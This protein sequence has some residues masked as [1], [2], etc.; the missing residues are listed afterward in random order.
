MNT[1]V[2]LATQGPIWTLTLN[3]P[4]RLNAVCESLYGALEQ[5]LLDAEADPA[6]QVVI[7]A[8][9]GRAFCAGADLKLHQSGRTEAQ[10]RDYLWQEQRVCRQLLTLNKPV[11]CALQGYAIGAGLELA[12]NT[13][14]RIG[15]DTL[16]VS[17]PELG[18]GNY[19]G[20]GVTV[21]LPALVG[22]AQARRLL[23]QPERRFT[24]AELLQMGLLD[25]VVD[26]TELQEA[27]LLRAEALARMPADNLARARQHLR[28]GLMNHYDAALVDEWQ[29]M[30]AATGSD[31]W[32]QKVAGA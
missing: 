20:G 17:L 23:L 22:L 11:L 25:A 5:A 30:V 12:L 3:R 2:L 8:G 24:A 19:V 27:T 7:L 9:S 13:D 10:R 32:H 21:L 29:A 4:E 26:E 18:I 28:R 16:Q 14:W 1:D 31:A 15:A 6:C